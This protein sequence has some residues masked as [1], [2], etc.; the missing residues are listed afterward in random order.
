MAR[1]EVTCSGSTLPA[2]TF[3]RS[4]LRLLAN[5]FPTAS[6]DGSPSGPVLSSCLL[7][8]CGTL[9]QRTRRS[10]L[11]V[12][13]SSVPEEPLPKSLHLLCL[14]RWPIHDSAQRSEESTTG[15]SI[16][17]VWF[18]APC[19]VSQDVGRAHPSCGAVHSRRME[20]ENALSVAIC[21][22]CSCTPVYI[23]FA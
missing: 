2:S 20:L 8:D 10:S 5:K 9:S 19:A 13:S 4:S 15:C 17:V 11:P 14:L 23:L 16:R 18:L 12:E 22:S 1:P 21:R 6:V 3:L 7:E